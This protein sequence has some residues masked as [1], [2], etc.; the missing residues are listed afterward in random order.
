MSEYFRASGERRQAA[1]TRLISVE[2]AAGRLD[3][4]PETVRKMIHARTIE[5]V[6]IGRAF[7]ISEAALEAWVARR[8]RAAQVEAGWGK[9]ARTGMVPRRITKD[10][11]D[12]KGEAA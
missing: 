12:T 4:H 3:L 5:Y 10:T 6:R 7:K 1:M 8:T 2:E 9:K 11:K